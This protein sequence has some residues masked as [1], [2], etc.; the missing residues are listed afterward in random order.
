MKDFTRESL[1]HCPV[2]GYIPFTSIVPPGEV[3]ERTLLD[4]PWLQR[5]RQIH[6]LQTAWW[7]YPSA[8]HTRFQHVVGAMHMASRTVDA[9]YPSLHEVCHGDVP[10]RGYVECLARMAALLHDV[11]HGPFGHFFDAHFLKPHY[12]LNHEV[13]GAHI[14]EHELGELLRGVREC[15]NTRM[16][17]G[18]SLDPAQVAT[19]IMRPK[20]H[21]ADQHP[22]WLILLRSLFCGLYTVDNMDFVLRD[23]YMSGYSSRAYD[24]DRLLRYSFFSDRGLTIHQKGMNALLKFVQTKSELFRAVYFHRTVR[25]IDK[26]LEG[27]FRDSRELLFPGNPLEHLED[28][29]GFTEWSLLIDVSRWSKFDDPATRSLGQRWDRLLERQVDWVCVEDRNQTVREG[30]SEQTSVFADENVLEQVLRGKLPGEMRDLPMQID[31][32]RHIYRPDALAATA[33]Q[34]FQYSPATGKV[35][36]LTDDQLFKQLP[37]AHRACRI[38]LRKDHTSEQASAIGAALDAIVGSRGEDDLTNM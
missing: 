34:N 33:G 29:R 3:S 2:H 11:G 26:T 36:P 20:T 10:S 1:L 6:Q 37:L 9:L 13:L 25:A 7:V 27:L 35:Y 24:L 17:D 32:P 23:A 4:N 15:P 30:E 22:R 18:E 8:E 31:L 5:L 21:D 14:I 19:L 16:A 38:Y 12:G 28:Y